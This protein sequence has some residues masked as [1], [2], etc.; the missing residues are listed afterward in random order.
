MGRYLVHVGFMVKIMMGEASA[1]REGE[2]V[3]YEV[4]VMAIMAQ[5]QL[6]FSLGLRGIIAFGLTVSP[7]PSPWACRVSSPL[8]S[9]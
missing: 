4:E 3:N 5:A 7:S 6:T 9:Q 1:Q 2:A 8:A